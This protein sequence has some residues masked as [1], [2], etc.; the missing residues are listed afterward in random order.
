MF[1]NMN[2]AKLLGILAILVV[3]YLAFNFFD[4]GSR[5]KEF[6][7]ELVVIDSAKVDKIII[8]KEDEKLELRKEGEQWKVEISEG[9]FKHATNNSVLQTI[10]S[11]MSIKPSRV[12]ARSEDKWKDYQVDSLGTKV[13]IFE[14][15]NNT[16]DLIIG[17]LQFVDQRNYFTYVRLSDE[18]DTYI[19]NNFLAMAINTS[20]NNF[21]DSKVL[22]INKD[23][24]QQISFNYSDSSFVLSKINDQW[25]IDGNPTDSTN[26]AKFLSSL[27]RLNNS[28][29]YDQELPSVS[30]NFTV[31]IKENN[32]NQTEIKGWIEG[33]EN[34]IVSSSANTENIFNDNGL[35]E[36]LF[37]SK[38]YFFEDE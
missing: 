31:A 35:A 37:K 20:P 30:S 25:I 28:N 22:S 16:L 4:K 17:R 13:Q 36:K 11:I 7:S 32:G 2:T 9:Q 23:S 5:S 12:V 1:K 21:R 3:V 18:K 29:F 34:M 8:Q 14:E 24:I 15:G 26:T 19:A 27:N 10:E 38:S 33:T 6:K